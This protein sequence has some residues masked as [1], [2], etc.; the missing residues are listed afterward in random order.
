VGA[1]VGVDEGEDLAG[2]GLHGVG[3]REG[4]IGGEGAVEGDG[5]VGPAAVHDGQEDGRFGLHGEKGHAGVEVGGAAEEGDG[6]AGVAVAQVDEKGQSLPRPEVGKGAPEHRGVAARDELDA[7]AAPEPQ[8]VVGDEGVVL[9]SGEGEDGDVDLRREEGGEFPVAGMRGGEDDA[10]G[11]VLFPPAADGFEGAF[12]VVDG[13]SPGFGAAVRPDEVD[14]VEDEVEEGLP[15]DL[16]DAA[17]GEGV[18]EDLPDAA[19]GFAAEAEGQGV[20]KA[21]Q[22][23]GEEVGEAEGEEDSLASR[24]RTAARTLGEYS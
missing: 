7:V 5:V 10:G 9:E 8:E 2:E 1:D 3:L 18:A 12:G 14:G 20:G 24:S 19:A 6:D 23:P 21:G 13:D 16:P 17:G 11:G 15:G 4:G 22:G